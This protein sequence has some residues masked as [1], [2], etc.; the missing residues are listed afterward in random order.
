MAKNSLKDR[1]QRV[2][3]FIVFTDLHLVSVMKSQGQVLRK[4][5]VKIQS[6]AGRVERFM[7]C[8]FREYQ[9]SV[10]IITIFLNSMSEFQL[11]F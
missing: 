5:A 10:D 2:N 3:T 7:L 1:A 6:K 11:I 9:I 8:L 4:G